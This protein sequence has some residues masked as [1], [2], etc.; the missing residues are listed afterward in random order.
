MFEKLGVV[1]NSW[2][3]VLDSGTRFE[4]LVDR[5]C[6]AG[7][8]QIEI[9]DGDYLRN[10]AFGELISDLEGIMWHHDLYRWCEICDSLHGEPVRAIRVHRRRN[11]GLHCHNGAGR[12]ECAQNADTDVLSAA[13]EF[14]SETA[15]AVYSFA[16]AFPWMADSP[17]HAADNRRIAT[18]FRLAYLLNP[19]RP[20]VRLVSL[21]HLDSIDTETAVGNLRR[22]RDVLPDGR[23]TLTVENARYP[24]SLILDLAGAGGVP[25]A[26]DEANNYLPDGKE[27]GN[28]EDFWQKVRADELASVHL[29]QTGSSGALSRLGDGYVDFRSLLRRLEE[30][31]YT[32]DLLFELAPTDDPL[33]DVLYSRDYLYEIYSS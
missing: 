1:S 4:E 17:D 31:G 30:G 2:R 18:A 11:E 5:H 33:E 23:A 32:G 24:A 3:K 26:Y 14:I 19:Q 28:T 12:R 7:L 16:M 21:V 15:G 22:Y 25:L 20:R 13:Q 27:L 9:R 29:K 8:K 10:S 6:R